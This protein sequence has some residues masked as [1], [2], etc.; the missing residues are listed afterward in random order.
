MKVH[1]S[2]AGDYHIRITWITEDKK[3]LSIVEYGTGSGEYTSVES[4]DHTSYRYFLYTSGKIHR[5]KIGPLEPGTTYYYRCGG[6]GP[7]FSFRTPPSF[8][9]VEFAVVGKFLR[10]L[11]D[12]ES[13]LFFFSRAQFLSSRFDS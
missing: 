7:E 9:P 6:S 5:V 11:K 8:F 4:G 10:S 12:L 2:L 1:I 13:K 3:A